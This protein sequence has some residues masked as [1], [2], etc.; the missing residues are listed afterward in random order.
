MPILRG[1]FDCMLHLINPSIP[2]SLNASASP[3]IC[4]AL[5]LQCLDTLHNTVALSWPWYFCNKPHPP[6]HRQPPR[7]QCHQP[8]VHRNDLRPATTRVSALPTILPVSRQLGH[9]V[10][11]KAGLDASTQTPPP[12]VHHP[13]VGR[14]RK[15]P[16][17]RILGAHLLD[18]PPCLLTMSLSRACPTLASPLVTHLMQP[19]LS[20]CF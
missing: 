3:L 13:S 19:Y 8:A 2:L 7:C 4:L 20:I 6:T 1:H 17:A 14:P 12:T 5:P 15:R 9:P 16:L 11:G 10:H 18:V